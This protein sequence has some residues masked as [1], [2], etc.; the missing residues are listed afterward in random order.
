MTLTVQER[1]DIVARLNPALGPDGQTIMRTLPVTRYQPLYLDVSGA[2]EEP[3]AS[4][5]DPAFVAR[6]RGM[7]AEMV[8]ER[9]AITT[10]EAVAP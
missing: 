2:L 1:L 10:K 4:D 8:R 7:A 9:D 6:V 3:P 5:L